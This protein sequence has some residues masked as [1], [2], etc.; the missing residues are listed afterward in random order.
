MAVDVPG[1]GPTELEQGLITI[2]QKT[3][4]E[5]MREYVPNVI[6]PSFGIGRILYALLEHTYWTREGDDA[7]GVLSIPAMMAPT[8]VLVCPLSANDQFRPL[9]A[10]LTARLRQ[11]SV[12][13]RVDDSGAS[14]GKR[15][16][17]NDKSI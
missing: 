13:N 3:R 8:K 10:K 12:S 16:V 4:I 6:E 5:S 11:V 14:I 15:Y 7:R 2:S 1:V 17:G 9:T